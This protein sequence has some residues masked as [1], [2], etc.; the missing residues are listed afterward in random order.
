MLPLA[1]LPKN[2]PPSARVTVSWPRGC[3]P[4]RLAL[5]ETLPAA[6]VSVRLLFSVARLSIVA[7]VGEEHVPAA[8]GD[9]QA[10]V[11]RHG[12]VEPDRLPLVVTVRSW[13]TPA[14]PSKKIPPLMTFVLPMLIW[15]VVLTS[16][17][18]P[19]SGLLPLASLPKNTPP[20]ACVT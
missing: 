3:V 1:S 19:R 2:T 13:F 7:V 18:G 17:R 11:Q 9:R 16:V 14:P 10:A 6:A 8:R 4:P 12:A 15:S 5:K 20:S